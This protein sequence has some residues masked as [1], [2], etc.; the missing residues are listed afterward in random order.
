NLASR[1]STLLRKVREGLDLEQAACS[2]FGPAIGGAR[3]T[4]FRC[5]V[6]SEELEILWAKPVMSA[7]GRSMD[8]AY[9][10]PEQVDPVVAWLMVRTTG[11]A[12]IRYRQ[13]ASLHAE[14]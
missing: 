14:Q 8:V 9:G 10:T 1:Y 2:G 13:P 3:F 12:S 7:D 11:S 4:R 6:I 5:H